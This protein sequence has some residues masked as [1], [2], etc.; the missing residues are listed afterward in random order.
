M[1]WLFKKLMDRILAGAIH[2]GRLRVIWP[3]GSASIYGTGQSKEATI[4][5]I[6]EAVLRR[7]VANPGLAFGEAYMDEG[8][9]PVNFSMHDV[10]AVLMDNIY[11]QHV[12]VLALNIKIARWLRRSP[13][14]P[15]APTAS[16]FA[17]R[18]Y[19]ANHATTGASTCR[20]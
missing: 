8:I 11:R 16:R 9:I 10:L 13:P 3:D 1:T 7:L 18:D 15:T 19:I 14:R 4:K 6:D 5:I 17:S 12:P 2:R 20:P